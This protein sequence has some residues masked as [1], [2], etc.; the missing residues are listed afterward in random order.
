MSALS[1]VSLLIAQK[2]NDIET[3]RDIFKDEI[4]VFVGGL[5]SALRRA[6]S[7]PWSSARVRL[8][9]PREVETEA[10]AVSRVTDHYAIGRVGVRFK[11]GTLFTQ[12]AEIKFGFE[13]EDP[14]PAFTWQ[15]SFNLMSRYLR[16]D[17]LLW[18]VLKTSKQLDLPGQ[19]HREKTNTVVFACRP[20]DAALTAEVA[21]SD[22]K[23]VMEF[24]LASDAAIA[25]AV[26]IDPS[27]S[28]PEPVSASV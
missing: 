1:E 10:K 18:S 12:V 16:M 3:A 8:D 25:E 19:V 22:L 6:R 11:K 2:A 14:S 13:L 7:D 5:V 26:G 23:S 24:V 28:A 27:P 4:N 15:V 17:D 21:F 20:I 9:L